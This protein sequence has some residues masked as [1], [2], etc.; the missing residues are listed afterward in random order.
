M[1]E[2]RRLSNKSGLNEAFFEFTG[3]NNWN[4]LDVTRRR[5]VRPRGV[6]FYTG[7]PIITRLVLAP[8]QSK[9]F[10]FVLNAA[11]RSWANQGA[12]IDCKQ[13]EISD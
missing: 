13:T 2:L 7:H 4:V 12:E 1:I 6:G 5:L 3:I 9:I 8:N 11:I 10:A